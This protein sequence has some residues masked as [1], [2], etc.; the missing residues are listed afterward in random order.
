MTIFVAGFGNFVLLIVTKFEKIDL[1]LTESCGE[2]S[3]FQGG[4]GAFRLLWVLIL[5]S[6]CLN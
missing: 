1:D 3:R 2:I 5:S 6:M 4:G